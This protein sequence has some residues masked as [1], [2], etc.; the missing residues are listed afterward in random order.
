MASYL[1]AVLFLIK[2]DVGVSF[3]SFFFSVSSFA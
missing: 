3:P 1:L 2:A